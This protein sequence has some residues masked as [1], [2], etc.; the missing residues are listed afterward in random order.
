MNNLI[1]RSEQLD[2]VFVLQ[3]TMNRLVDQLSAL[4]RYIKRNMIDD[5]QRKALFGSNLS[6]E[7]RWGRGAVGAS[8]S[9][10]QLRLCALRRGPKPSNVCNAGPLEL[11]ACRRGARVLAGQ[12]ECTLQVR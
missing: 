3:E 5:V 6:R 11:S 12:T 1:I 10:R 4:E 7:H 8:P 9:R 2:G